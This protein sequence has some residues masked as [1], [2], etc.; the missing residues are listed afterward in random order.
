MTGEVRSGSKAA[1]LFSAS[2]SPSTSCGHS[3][4]Q[5]HPRWPALG[6]QNGPRMMLGRFDCGPRRNRPATPPTSSGPRRPREAARVRPSTR[7]RSPTDR[8]TAL[9][10]R[11]LCPASNTE[12][13][14]FFARGGGGGGHVHPGKR[15]GMGLRGVCGGGL[16][17]L[18]GRPR[19]REGVLK[20]ARRQRTGR[21]P[22]GA[23][24]SSDRGPVGT[25]RLPRW[26]TGP[27]WP[28]KCYQ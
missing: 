4:R 13:A 8:R 22:R 18:P 5:D 6:E 24:G 16:L 28:V 2:M 7:G 20:S 26:V 10:P 12:G 15:G 25:R 1:H 17:H 23:P 27:I 14:L 9:G 19:S 11:F 3:L 21:R